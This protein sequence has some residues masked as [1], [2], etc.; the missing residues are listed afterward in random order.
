MTKRTI[1]IKFDRE[2]FHVKEINDIMNCIYNQ[3]DNTIQII[4]MFDGMK[5][6]N[7]NILES[8]DNNA[9]GIYFYEFTDMERMNQIIEAM[10]KAPLNCEDF[11]EWQEKLP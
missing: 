4:P 2:K 5:I 10:I 1:A 7:T 9:G 8:E 11:D 6:Y 3:I